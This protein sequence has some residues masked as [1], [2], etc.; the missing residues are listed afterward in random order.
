[1]KS[2]PIVVTMLSRACNRTLI[3]KPQHRG[4]RIAIATDAWSPQVNGVV[5]TLKQTREQLV[6][7][8]PRCV[9]D[10]AGRSSHISMSDLSGNTPRP[11]SRDEK[12]PANWMPSARRLHSCRNRGNHWSRRPAL[13]P[14]AKL[15]VH[16]RVS[17]P[18]PGVCTARACRFRLPGLIALLALVSPACRRTMAATNS[19][20]IL[21]KHRGF[22]NVVL[23]T[24]GVDAAIFATGKRRTT[25]TFPARS[26][27]ASAGSPLKRTSRSS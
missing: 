14:Q 4:M 8:R 19:I 21:L 27:S 3:C 13:L 22:R 12:L 5:N 23:W 2:R 7:R 18:V 16:H 10:Y 11:C 1:M 17:H 15:S 25:T 6:R 24:R 9:D 26:G 20:R